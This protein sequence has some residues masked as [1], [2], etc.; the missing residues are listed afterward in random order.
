MRAW[1]ARGGL[2]DRS[3]T[4][5][6]RLVSQGIA[7]PSLDDTLRRHLF[8]RFTIGTT[9]AIA[10]SS[11]MES[12]ADNR[13][14]DSCHIRRR[15]DSSLA[16]RNA[17]L[18]S[19]PLSPF[20]IALLA[21]TRCVGRECCKRVRDD[22]VSPRFDVTNDVR[23]LASWWTTSRDRYN[24]RSLFDEARSLSNCDR[25]SPLERA[26]RRRLSPTGYFVAL[27]FL[28]LSFVLSS[29]LPLFIM[30]SKHHRPACS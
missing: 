10:L 28:V 22:H 24:C 14:N 18:L 30:I 12:L 17:P 11:E 3:T 2:V 29:L 19:T 25:V 20:R 8:A 23:L 16:N 4:L 13:R 27:F 7:Y 15:A 5:R 1:N 21:V 9:S 26:E 6:D